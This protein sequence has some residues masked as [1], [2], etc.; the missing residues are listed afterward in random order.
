MNLRVC[1]L[2]NREPAGVVNILGQIPVCILSSAFWRGPPVAQSNSST[3]W[4]TGIHVPV[5]I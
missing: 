5:A 2:S 4:T 3:V 1:L